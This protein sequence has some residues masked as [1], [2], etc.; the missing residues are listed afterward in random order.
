MCLEFIIFKASV[1]LLAPLFFFQ[2]GVHVLSISFHFN[3]FYLFVYLVLFLP[4][5]FICHIVP[6]DFIFAALAP[7]ITT[8]LPVR[9]FELDLKSP[10]M[11]DYIFL[12]IY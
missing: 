10:H 5:I 2:N 9:S 6:K 3:F 11:A 4:Y 12:T 1:D 8:K 7:S